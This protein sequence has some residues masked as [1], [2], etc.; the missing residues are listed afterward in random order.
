MLWNVFANRVFDVFILA[1]RTRNFR[2]MHFIIC[3]YGSSRPVPCQY[4]VFLQMF[5][6]F[7]YVHEYILYIIPRRQPART[8]A[9]PFYVRS[10]PVL[11]LHSAV[12]C[13]V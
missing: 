1:S 13:T 9:V 10:R 8:A 3:I 5:Y 7:I 6:G 11:C 2:Y 12:C 4:R